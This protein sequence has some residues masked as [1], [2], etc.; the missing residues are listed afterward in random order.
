MLAIMKSD[1]VDS[2]AKVALR[3]TSSAAETDSPAGNKEIAHVGSCEKSTKHAYREAAEIC[4]LLK[5]NMLEDMDTCAKYSKVANEV[6]KIMAVEAYSSTE[7]IKRLDSELVVL[8]GSNI[9]ALT[10]LQLETTR[11]DIVD[12]KTNLDIVDI[13]I[14]YESVENEMGCYIPQF[15]TLSLQFLSFVLL[16]M[17]R[18]KSRLLLIIK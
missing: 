18:M 1:K 15:K 17:Q 8:K 13:K 5:P 9:S 6:A 11:Q 16:L 14:S 2:T 3:P 4:V 7:E 12:L 10:S